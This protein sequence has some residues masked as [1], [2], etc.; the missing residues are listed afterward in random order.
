MEI[1]A[2]C[3]C[4]QLLVCTYAIQGA[5][6]ECLV[7]VLDGLVDVRQFEEDCTPHEANV[8]ITFT[9]EKMFSNK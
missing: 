4:I 9:I 1:L 3:K 6:H 8:G 2:P 5:L 7:S